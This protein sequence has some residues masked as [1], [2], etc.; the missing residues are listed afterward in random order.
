MD[1]LY[2]DVSKFNHE[3]LFN[4]N[5][6]LDDIYKAIDDYDV[7]ISKENVFDLKM[8]FDDQYFNGEMEE[9]AEDE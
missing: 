5:I 3:T 1:Y 6:T 2:N 8:K 4:K 7:S 9:E